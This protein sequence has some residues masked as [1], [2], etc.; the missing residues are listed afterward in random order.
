MAIAV[1]LLLLLLLLLLPM[2]NAALDERP[3]SL[4]VFSI[5]TPCKACV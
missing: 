3:P 5:K 4:C 2:E 1:L